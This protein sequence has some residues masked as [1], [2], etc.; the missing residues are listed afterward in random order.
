MDELVASIQER[1]LGALDRIA[2]AAKRSGRSPEAVKLVVVTKAQP[3]ETARAAIEAG[4]R[5]LGENYAEEGV[6]KIQ[7]LANFSA[8]EWHMIGHVQSRK[9]QLV[10]GNFNFMHSLDSLKLAKRLDRFCAEAGRILPVLL[11]VNVGGEESK[12]GWNAFVESKWAGLPDELAVIFT[13]PN[14]KVLGLMSMPPLGDDAESSRPYFQKLGRLRE[15]LSSQFP[16]AVLSEL[17]MGTS[18]DYEVAV[19]EGATYVRVGTAIVGPRQIKTE[20]V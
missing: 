3:V 1:Y 11:E 18:F 5:I 8:V 16:Q 4:V 14:L 19:E 15:F 6:T 13:L 10:A 12:S 2:G 17:S 7:S 20:K 9:A